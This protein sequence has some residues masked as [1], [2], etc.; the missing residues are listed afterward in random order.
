MVGILQ[1]SPGAATGLLLPGQ[2]VL[3]DLQSDLLHHWTVEDLTRTTVYR[4][5]SWRD[6]AGGVELVAEGDARPRMEPASLGGQGALEFDSSSTIARYL[7]TTSSTAPVIPVG[8]TY[9]VAFYRRSPAGSIRMT[10]ARNTNNYHSFGTST[11]AGMG[12]MVGGTGTANGAFYTGDLRNKWTAAVAVVEATRTRLYVD[13]SAE[14]VGGSGN[15]SSIGVRL[16]AN[17]AATPTNQ[18][19]GYM[20]DYRIYGR[21]FTAAE[22]RGLIA[23]LR[24]R[25]GFA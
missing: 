17:A 13:D 14:I 23:A 21:A 5:A 3:P 9:G 22:A 6:R 15:V 11:N 10:S 2:P 12:M 16:G 20:A 8:T 18:F 25:Y 1:R 7:Q 19:S 4:V 24:E